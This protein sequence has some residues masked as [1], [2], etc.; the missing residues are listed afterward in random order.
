MTCVFSTDQDTEFAG[1]DTGGGVFGITKTL[2][3]RESDL[4][5]A[6]VRGK[7]LLI[8]DSPYIVLDISRE[9]GMLVVRLTENSPA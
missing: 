1:D 6:P 8:D 7:A 5:R 2:H 4:A 3:C 9:M